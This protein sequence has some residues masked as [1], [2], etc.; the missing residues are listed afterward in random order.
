VLK[1]VRLNSQLLFVCLLGKGEMK[2]SFKEN[3]EKELIVRRSF[4]FAFI[5]SLRQKKNLLLATFRKQN[6]CNFVPRI[7]LFCRLHTLG[8]LTS[9]AHSYVI[10]L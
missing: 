2:N 7:S 3:K 10:L 6:F 5:H 1:R 9:D 8:F 4:T